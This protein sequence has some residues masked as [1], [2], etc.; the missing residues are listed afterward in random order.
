MLSKTFTAAMEINA[1]NIAKGDDFF[2]ASGAV[3]MPLG[4]THGKVKF[5][6]SRGTPHMLSVWLL[7][8][9]VDTTAY[10]VLLGTEFK[11]A[12]RGI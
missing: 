3:E 5:T 6:F 8:T 9:V 12:M 2:T 11:A 4:V 10:D 1:I 7:V